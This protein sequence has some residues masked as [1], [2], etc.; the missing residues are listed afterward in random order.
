MQGHRVDHCQFLSHV[1]LFVAP[2]TVACQASLYMEFSRQEYW[3]GM[4]FPPPGDLPYP[5]IESMSPI[6][7]ADSLLSEPPELISV[8]SHFFFSNRF[9]VSRLR[10]IVCMIYLLTYS[11]F[12]M[13]KRSLCQ[14]K[15]ENKR[16]SNNSSFGDSLVWYKL[17]VL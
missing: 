6:L 1:V 3:S 12:N 10:G 14:Y 11:I 7:H 8:L 4:S 16:N 13:Q 5:G 17:F 2:W 9:C 15:Q